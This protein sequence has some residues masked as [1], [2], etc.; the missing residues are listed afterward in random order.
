MVS[1]G[2]I[3]F[4]SREECYVRWGWWWWWLWWWW[5]W[6]YWEVLVGSD[7]MMGI[8]PAAPLT[9]WPHT[10][11]ASAPWYILS[12]RMKWGSFILHLILDL[13]RMFGVLRR[14]SEKRSWERKKAEHGLVW[15][16]WALGRKTIIYSHFVFLL[17]CLPLMRISLANNRFILCNNS[18]A[19]QWQWVSLGIFA[20]GETEETNI[21]MISPPS[22]PDFTSPWL[23]GL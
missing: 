6:W 9:H 18:S 1:L 17:F 20:N 14:G 10:G 7:V 4:L 15:G 12:D 11:M 3:G 19:C 23:W 5:Y 2:S 21:R 8:H 13:T 22:F 16:G